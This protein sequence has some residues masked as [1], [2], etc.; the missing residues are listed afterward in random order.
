M[1]DVS[2]RKHKEVLKLTVNHLY[3]LLRCIRSRWYALGERLELPHSDLEAIEKDYATYGCDRCL[4]EL[5][6]LW[7]ERCTDHQLSKMTEA[8]KKMHEEDLAQKFFH[9][10]G[11]LG[12]IESKPSSN[13]FSKVHVPLKEY[14]YEDWHLGFQQFE[15]DKLSHK[16]IKGFQLEIA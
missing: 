6:A 3:Y 5:F 12:R 7:I 14:C 10:T 11:E 1:S 15:L 13:L 4:I 2:S 9:Y 16:A 8:L